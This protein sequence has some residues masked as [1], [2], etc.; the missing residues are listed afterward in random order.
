MNSLENDVFK[1]FV[2]LNKSEKDYG[3]LA[4]IGPN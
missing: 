4:V 2:K 1:L 3:T